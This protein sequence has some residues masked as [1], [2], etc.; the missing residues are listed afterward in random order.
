MLEPPGPLRPRRL[1]QRRGGL[2]HRPWFRRSRL[3]I[4]PGG[5]RRWTPRRP[6]PQSGRSRLLPRGVRSLSGSDPSPAGGITRVL[7]GETGPT[8]RG[9][10]CLPLRT[11]PRG[12]LG[13][14]RAIPPTGG[15]VDA[16]SD[17]CYAKGP[18]RCYPGTHFP[19]SCRV[20]FSPSPLAVFDVRLCLFRSSSPGPLGN[21]CSYE[22]RGASGSSS[23]GK[24]A[25]LPTPR[26][27]CRCGVLKWRTSAFVVST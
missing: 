22:G 26:S 1:G 24:R 23:G 6:A 25:Y 4:L 10:L 12:A 14:P 8:L 17:V 2:R 13:H 20:V 9:S 19:F 11:L 5:R 15:A 18:A 16:D 3:R 27:Y 21:R 7:H